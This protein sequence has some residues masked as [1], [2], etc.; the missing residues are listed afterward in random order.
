M[1][2]LGRAQLEGRCHFGL[3]YTRGNT[4]AK[5][6]NPDLIPPY[7][8]VLTENSELLR[9]MLSDQIETVVRRLNQKFYLKDYETN[10]ILK[11]AN[12]S[13]PDGV[14]ELIKILKSCNS[15]NFSNF[16]GCLKELGYVGLANKLEVSLKPQSQ[17]EPTT[18]Y[19]TKAAVNDPTKQAKRKRKET[20][21]DRDLRRMRH[22][23]VELISGINDPKSLVDCLDGKGLLLPEDKQKIELEKLPIDKTRKLLDILMCDCKGAFPDFVQ[24][25]K[26]AQYYSLA[27][28]LE[29]EDSEEEE[30]EQTTERFKTEMNRIVTFV[31][32]MMPDGMK[33]VSKSQMYSKLTVLGVTTKDDLLSLEAGDFVGILKIVPARKL[34]ANIKRK[35]EKQN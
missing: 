34:L 30:S 26:D 18:R 14:T 2:I 21:T 31:M 22:A 15:E 27:E 1:T 29:E 24:C 23:K 16:L 4:V 32:E 5:M 28:R 25:L 11:K 8:R 12:K 17:R 13:P 9:A 35:L 33:T 20:M 10:D 6:M 19:Q 3:Q 7:Q